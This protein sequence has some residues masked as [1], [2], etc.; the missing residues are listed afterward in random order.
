LAVTWLLEEWFAEKEFNEMI[1][2]D[3][4]YEKWF[5]RILKGLKDPNVL[6]VKDRTFTRFLLDVPEVTDEAINVVVKEY[7]EN[8]G[9]GGRMVLGLGTLRDLINL[10]PAVRDNSLRLLMT[11]CTHQGNLLFSFFFFFLIYIFFVF[12]FFFFFVNIFFLALSCED[13]KLF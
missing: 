3:K 4:Q 7:C 2:S 10:R 1:E 8:I 6:D 5:H 9:P 11:F 12:F 13:S